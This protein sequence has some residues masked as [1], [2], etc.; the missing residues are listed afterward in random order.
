MSTASAGAAERLVWMDTLRGVA[1]LLVMLSHAIHL[2]PIDPPRAVI[3]LDL[4]V[5]PFRIPAL[6]FLSGMLLARS[7]AKP[8]PVYLRGK[9]SR[10]LWP[11]LLWTLIT[12]AVTSFGAPG[13]NPLIELLWRPTS[14]M[15]YLGYLFVY[16]LAVMFL[17]PG[18]RTW[19]LVP[20][21]VG[22]VLAAPTTVL[23]PF[24]SSDAAALPKLLFCF[25][26]FLCGDVLTRHAARWH[27]VLTNVRTTAVCALLA[28]PAVVMSVAGFE[29]RFQP[30]YLVSTL[31]GIVATIPLFTWLAGTGVG[32]FSAAQGR[33]S[34]VFYVTH[35]PVQLV[36][37][38]VAFGLGLRSGLGITAF[39]LG[40]AL[41]AGFAMVWLRSRWP[42]IDYLYDLHLER[43]VRR[44]P[45]VGRL[46][47]T[48]LLRPRTNGRSPAAAGEA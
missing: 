28:L 20:T 4:A 6:M 41:A 23:D 12:L 10:I 31:A 48:P 45:R 24:T 26:C 38:H 14:A 40:A 9:V 32:A 11:Y 44:V 27:P 19:L 47:S 15:W 25:F 43:R 13:P 33:S 3:T 8:R 18:Q 46:A 5:T 7:V 39:N 1:V 42:R 34:I 35:W 29:V 17:R 2:S 37:Y 30:C 22:L 16:Y 36:A 21:A